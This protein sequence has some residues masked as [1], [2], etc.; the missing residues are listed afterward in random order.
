MAKSKKFI[1]NKNG[2]YDLL[3]QYDNSNEFA[4]DFFSRDK[5]NKNRENISEFINQQ[6][7][8][9]KVSTV[10]LMVS[11]MLLAA[12]PMTSLVEANAAE[13]P[14]YSMAYLYGGSAQ[15]QIG[16]VEQ[17][18][19]SLQTVSPSY[20]DINTDGSL[21]LNSVS[22][23]LIDHMHANKIRVVPFVS[24]HWDRTAGINALK[25]A[26]TITTQIAAYVNQY[27]LDGVNVDIENVT[28]LQ[29]S[30]YTDFV[31]LL[32]QKIPAEKEVSVAVAANP[33]NWATGWQGSYDYAELAKSSDYLMMMT[34]D[35]HYEGSA[36]GPVSSIQFVENSIQYALT[37][38][39]ADKL[40]V[41]LPLFGRIWS[42]NDTSIMGKGIPL[43][44]INQMI[45]DYKAVVTYDSASQSPKAEFEIKTGDKQYMAG[46]KVLPPG[47]YVVWFENA[48]SL[49]AKLDL[50][51]KY[52]LKGAGS[53][54]LGQEDASIWEKYNIWLNGEPLPEIPAD[55]IIYTVV[56]GDTLWKISQQFG[57]TIDEIKTLNNLTNDMLLVGQIL[58]ISPSATVTPPPI[59]PPVISET[60]AW[61]TSNTINLEVRSSVTANSTVVAVL[62]GST[63]VTVLG[64]PVGSFS[65][66]RLE[67]GQTGYVPSANLTTVQPPA[68][69][70]ITK[71]TITKVN[72][73]QNASNSGKNL[74][75]INKG[76]TV[77][78]LDTIGSYTKISYNGIV[79]YVNS[80]DLK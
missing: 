26:D 46:G 41:G 2:T 56:A 65:Q 6:A 72:L 63:K 71:V 40:V 14:K 16:Y 31:R 50:I 5:I 66:I 62:T 22:K 24:N 75:T 59:Q 33:N 18:H 4:M 43:N 61:I 60:T 48:Q 7:K 38:A 32:R 37:K 13:V 30:Q 79:G 69:Q 29:R 9:L 68:Q 49:E 78:V 73:R 70:I 64:E 54:A 19:N 57:T 12:I 42:T 51:R 20:F 25:N 17:T 45:V 52:D 44:T 74:A 55:S 76:T 11:G 8:N 10:K 80:S 21:K 28:E 1:P 47:K 58:K 39:S 15:Q 23:E 36:A 3:I 34:Y 35:E 67:N 53:W 27:N 77:T